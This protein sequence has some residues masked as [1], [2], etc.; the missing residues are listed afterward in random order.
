[1]GD[2]VICGYALNNVGFNRLIEGTPSMQEMLPS[3]VGAPVILYDTW[4]SK[5]P[6]RTR[7]AAPKVR[8]MF[9]HNPHKALY[10]SSGSQAKGIPT[11]ETEHFISSQVDA[12]PTKASG[13]SGVSK[14]S[15]AASFKRQ[16]V[17]GLSCVHGSHSSKGVMDP[18]FGKKISGSTGQ[19]IRTLRYIHF[20]GLSWVVVYSSKVVE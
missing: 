17:T 20:D 18:S 7:K 11:T 4:R 9:I 19:L 13:S 12:R 14:L 10:S 1:M 15:P 5:L 16:S 2:A 8:C 3:Y 6:R